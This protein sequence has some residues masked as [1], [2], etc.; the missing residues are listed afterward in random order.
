MMNRITSFRLNGFT[1]LRVVSLIKKK[2]AR[3]SRI[4]SMVIPVN[5]EDVK[6]GT[7]AAEIK[8]ERKLKNCEYYY[9]IFSNGLMI[10]PTQ[11]KGYSDLRI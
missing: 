4:C 10:A 1:A 8:L 9:L 11:I 5:C 7:D 6:S 2:G 3:K